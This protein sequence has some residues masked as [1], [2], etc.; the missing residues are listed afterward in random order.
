MSSTHQLHTYRTRDFSS[1]AERIR[2]MLLECGPLSAGQIAARMPKTADGRDFPEGRVTART[3]K[4]REQGALFTSEDGHGTLLF[5]A[6][7]NEK[8]WPVRAR[9]FAKAKELKAFAEAAEYLKPFLPGDV[10][11]GLRHQYAKLRAQP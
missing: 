4:L 10:V 11:E 8:H 6:E 9:A 5:H 3:T 2:Q 7:P 1:Q